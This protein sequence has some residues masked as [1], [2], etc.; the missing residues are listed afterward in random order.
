MIK[1]LTIGEWVMTSKLIE[2]WHAGGM[3]LVA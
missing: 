3:G 1:E 2:I